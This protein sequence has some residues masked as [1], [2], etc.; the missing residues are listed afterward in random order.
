MPINLEE[1][2]KKI[3]LADKILSGVGRILKKHWWIILIGLIAW[4]FYWSLTSEDLEETYE[5]QTEQ[6]ND[7]KN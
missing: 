5:Y 4:F 3:G 7:Y 2:E 6:T 1:I